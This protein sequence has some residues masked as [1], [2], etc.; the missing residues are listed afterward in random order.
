MLSASTVCFIRFIHLQILTWNAAGAD[1]S[2]PSTKAQANGVKEEQPHAS[3]DWPFASQFITATRNG[4]FAAK[5]AL[6]VGL[7]ST[8]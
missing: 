6:E 2:K 5:A 3:F 7:F 1:D 8:L 4:L